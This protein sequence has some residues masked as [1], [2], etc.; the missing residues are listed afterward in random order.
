MELENDKLPAVLKAE[1]F[2]YSKENEQIV[3]RISGA[4]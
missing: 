1:E 4:K 3:K 2:R